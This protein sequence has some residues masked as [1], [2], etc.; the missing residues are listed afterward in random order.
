MERVRD[1]L[2]FVNGLIVAS[3]DHSEGLALL[4]TRKI[5]LSIKSFSNHHIDATI[6]EANSS[7]KWRITGFY[8]HPQMHLRHESYNLLTFLSNQMYLPW[9][10]F[11]DFNEILSMEENRGGVI[12]SQ[13][14]MEGFRNA[15]NSCG[16]KDLGFNGLDYMWCNMQ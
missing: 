11:G 4:W 5:N 2:G 9:F 10:C 7:L 12:R 1:R 6:T 16:F 3:R 15:I 13:S 14:Q 8:S